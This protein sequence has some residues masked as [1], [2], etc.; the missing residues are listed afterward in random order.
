MPPG[1]RPVHEDERQAILAD[2][3][4]VHSYLKQAM[5]TF[6]IHRLNVN[7]SSLIYR[8]KEELESKL[9]KVSHAIEFYCRLPVFVPIT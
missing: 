8:Q 3:R 5:D 6:P 9:N 2:L 7:R 4:D 1:K